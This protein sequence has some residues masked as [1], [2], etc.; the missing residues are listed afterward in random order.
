M[1]SNATHAMTFEC[2]KCWRGPRTSQMPSSGNFQ[3]VLEK[4]EQGEDQ[5][6]RAG[7]ACGDPDLSR[8]VERIDDFSVHVELELFRRR[9]AHSDGREPS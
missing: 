8:L 7:I 2:V 4:I 9:I 6:S 1:R 3:A 5:A